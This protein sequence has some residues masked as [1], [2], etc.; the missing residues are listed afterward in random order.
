MKVIKDTTCDIDIKMFKK[1]GEWVLE[2]IGGKGKKINVLITGDERIKELNKR[3]RGKDSSTDVLAFPYHDKDLWGEM[4]LSMD[5]IKENALKYEVEENEEILRVLIHGI[6]H[7]F[8]ERDAT[9]VEARKMINRQ[10]SLLKEFL[11]I[12]RRG[13]VPFG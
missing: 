10:E 13:E 3:F 5:R 12:Q 7:L 8:G 9:E 11:Q 6:L 4:V 1:C 2:K